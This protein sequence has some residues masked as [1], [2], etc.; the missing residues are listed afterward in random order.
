MHPPG[1][2]ST[3]QGRPSPVEQR[4]RASATRC[5]P[6]ASIRR[7]ASTA[8]STSRLAAGR[9]RSTSSRSRNRARARRRPSAPKCASCTTAAA[10]YIGVHAFD[11]QPSALVATEMR[12]DSDRLL[13]EDNFQLILDT[14]NDSRNGYMFVTTPLGA[15]LEQQISEEGEGNS[16]AAPSTRTSTATGTACGTSAARIDR[17]RLD[18][19][20]R[21]PAQHAA[22]LPTRRADVGHQLHAA[23]PPQERAGVLGADS[24][25]LHADARQPGRRA[26][27]LQSLSH[28]LR[29]QAEAVRG[30]PACATASRA[31]D[32][33][34]HDVAARR[35]PRRAAT[36]SPAG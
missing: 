18:R 12:R 28:G 11:A 21:H 6:S 2:P 24:E 17:R 8:C 22:L 15:K 25:G 1:D 31:A 35:R 3:T 14:F 5:R 10:C 33:A 7:R 20:D 34:D 32:T 16:R 26:R 29:P 4:Q 30:R 27:G 9:A 36:A 13:D 19:R 23:H